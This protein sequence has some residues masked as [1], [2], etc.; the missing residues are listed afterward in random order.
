MK[1]QL[2]TTQLQAIKTAIDADPVL[3]AKPMN[4]DGDFDIATALNLVRTPDFWVWRTQ[5]SKDELTNSVSQD[6]TTFA[7]TGAGFIT[8]SVG[9]RDAWRELFDRLG[10]VN[11]SLAN[12][13]QA[14][15]DIFSGATAPAPANRTHLATVSRR[16]ATLVE[17]VLRTNTAAGTTAA[18]DTMGAE[19]PITPY[20]V[21][22]ARAL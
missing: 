6:G 8:R 22:A 1:P 2:K 4:G 16:R 14:F 7:W 3:S 21:Q 15:T 5:V 11:P 9:E 10:N 18:P 12:V 19:G 17:H 20:E 13:R